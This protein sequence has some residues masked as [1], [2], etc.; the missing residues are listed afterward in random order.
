[1][2]ANLPRSIRD[3]CELAE[4]AILT[5]EERLACAHLATLL[6]LRRPELTPAQVRE[7]RRLLDQVAVFRTAS[8]APVRKRP[9]GFVR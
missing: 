5:E 7:S 3:L 1:M 2:S 9:V 4:N 8:S 6:S